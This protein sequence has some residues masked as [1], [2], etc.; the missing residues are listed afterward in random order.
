M[1]GN[2]KQ[3][4]SGKEKPQEGEELPVVLEIEPFGA[5]LFGKSFEDVVFDVSA[6]MSRF[7]DFLRE[8]D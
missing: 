5:S 2:P 1:Q 4:Q 7:A 8:E 3:R 6:E